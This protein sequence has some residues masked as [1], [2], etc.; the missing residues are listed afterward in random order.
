M[1]NNFNQKRIP[2]LEI[3]LLEAEL[4]KL[5]FYSPN[6]FVSRASVRVRA[7]VL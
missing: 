5:V 4:S 6:E 1:Q 2:V 3:W 7:D